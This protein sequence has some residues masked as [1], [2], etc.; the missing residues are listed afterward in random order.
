MDTSWEKLER[1]TRAGGPETE[2]VMKVV[3]F[4]EQDYIYASEVGHR[5]PSI[6]MYLK[7]GN[8]RPPGPEN[9]R[10]EPDVNKLLKWYEWL[11]EKVIADGW[12]EATV[13]PQLHVLIWGNK[14]GV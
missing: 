4:D 5:F 11:V 12:N 10:I 8:D 7:V 3:V 1:C 6:P 2:T 14:R 13:L 9:D